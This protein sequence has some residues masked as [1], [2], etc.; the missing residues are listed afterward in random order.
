MRKPLVENSWRASSFGAEHSIEPPLTLRRFCDAV[1]S[2]HS[3][4]WPPS[5]ETIAHEF[6]SLSG[7]PGFTQLKELGIFCE[8]LGVSVSVRELPIGLRGHNCAYRETRQIVVG[9]L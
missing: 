4:T 9:Q 8:R 1:V 7:V 5:E 3:G 2:E 6:V